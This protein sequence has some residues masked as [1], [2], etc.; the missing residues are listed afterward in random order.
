MILSCH[1]NR[2]SHLY[3]RSEINIPFGDITASRCPVKGGLHAAVRVA[4]AAPISSCPA[5]QDVPEA[6]ARGPCHRRDDADGSSESARETSVVRC[7]VWIWGAPCR[8][9]RT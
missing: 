2:R 3:R 8:R 1:H 6:I 7:E 9:D 5:L 4:E